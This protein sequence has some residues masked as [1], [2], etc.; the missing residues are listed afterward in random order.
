M[1]QRPRPFQKHTAVEAGP[2]LAWCDRRVT[3]Q[4]CKLDKAGKKREKERGK[5]SKKAS[6]PRRF[7]AKHPIMR[8]SCEIL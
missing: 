4:A 6:N 1:S 7:G 2:L 8:S 5:E 3:T